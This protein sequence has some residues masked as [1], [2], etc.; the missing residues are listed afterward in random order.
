M[1]L[2]GLLKELQD[3]NAN[4]LETIHK[5]VQALKRTR[6]SPLAYIEEMMN[7]QSPGYDEQE[8]AYIHRMLVTDEL[9]NRYKILHGG[10]TATFI[11]TAMGS[12]V[13]QEVGQDRRSVTLDLN[14]SFLKPA[15]EG[16]LTSQTR[17]IKKGRT[18]IVLET[19]VADERD[20]LIARAA[21]TF[22]RLS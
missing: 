4:E 21:G 20:R 16:W 8:E 1:T 18:I 15:V 3:L 9:K 22:F 6:I 12:T 2:D 13:F 14:I 11:D 10:I 5:Q 17:V 7:F 19:K